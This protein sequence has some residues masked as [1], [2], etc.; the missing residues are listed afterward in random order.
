[1]DV[2]K[3]LVSTI[4][5]AMPT[6]VVS[7]AIPGSDFQ[8]GPWTGAAWT[9]ESTG[10]FDSCSIFAVYNHNRTEL[11]FW[12]NKDYTM[13]IG[14]WDELG[15]FPAGNQ[16]SVSLKVDRRPP[17]YGTANFVSE[18]SAFV[19]LT[20]MDA[21]L[22]AMRRG[23]VLSIE[24]MYSRLEY[25][26]NGTSRAL[27]DAFNC[28][29]NYYD[30]RADVGTAGS[31]VPFWEPTRDQ[32][33]LMYQLSA[34]IAADLGVSGIVYR[35]DFPEMLVWDSPNEAMW[36][37]TA[38]GRLD[39][40]SDLLKT[41]FGED[42]ADLSAWCAGELA[43]V[44][45]EFVAEGIETNETKAL[46]NSDNPELNFNAHIIRQIIGQQVFEIVLFLSNGSD[47][48][49]T[50]R[51]NPHAGLGEAAALVAASFSR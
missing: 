3:I 5:L 2:L 29:S 1:M 34:A 32:E 39:P 36:V 23:N 51:S 48:N 30:Y 40:N 19:T 17:F 37:G 28:A 11:H 14:V 10:E 24:G 49:L 45:R 38:I 25:L 27:A 22:E 8:S 47:A 20:E 9:S 46:C 18:N 33:R 31:D 43:T 4:I 12:L 21:A 41:A 13:T 16:A 50:S 42:M 44:Q 35:D 7:E 26:L 15:R 6:S